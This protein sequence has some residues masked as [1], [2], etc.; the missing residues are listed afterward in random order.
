MHRLQLRNY[1]N[2]EI[3]FTTAV[4]QHVDLSLLPYFGFVAIP[5]LEIFQPVFFRY[6]RFHFLFYCFGELHLDL[7]LDPLLHMLL[8]LKPLSVK[9]LGDWG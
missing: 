9:I 5:N 4:C 7:C 6:C 3:N 1:C 8:F 2:Y